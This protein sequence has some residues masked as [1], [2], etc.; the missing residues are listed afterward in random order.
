MLVPAKLQCYLCFGGVWDK[1]TSRWFDG[2]HQ[3]WCRG[4]D[5]AAWANRSRHYLGCQTVCGRSAVEDRQRNGRK[6][7]SGRLIVPRLPIRQVRVRGGMQRGR[8]S[9]RT[10][11]WLQMC[12]SG[13]EHYRVCSVPR[14]ELPCT[15]AA[16]P[17]YHRRPEKAI[18]RDLAAGKVWGIS[19]G[20][21]LLE[22]SSSPPSLHNCTS[23]T[24]LL[25]PTHGSTSLKS[26]TKTTWHLNLCGGGHVVHKIGWKTSQW[27]Q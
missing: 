2:S 19:E 9:P 14:C 10:L 15:A 26:K 17:V 1:Y 22:V 20:K 11:E 24:A 12:T 18:M 13:P 27:G 7:R 4:P 5:L 8:N 6:T 16:D 3:R 25:F 21:E 23:V